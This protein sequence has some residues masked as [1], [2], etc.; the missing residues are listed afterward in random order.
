MELFD[1]IL[2]NTDEIKKLILQS[3]ENTEF[4]SKVTEE[5]N[6]L[7]EIRIFR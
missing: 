1:V 5:D 2:C 3:L 7:I 6:G 4:E